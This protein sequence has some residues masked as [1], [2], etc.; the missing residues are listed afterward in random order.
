MR[1]KRI[2]AVLL[3][4]VLLVSLFQAP[5]SVQAAAGDKLIALTFDDGP[6]RTNT[7]QLLDGLKQRGVNVTFFMVGSNVSSNLSLV[8][9]AYDEGHEVAGHTYD[10]PNLNTLGTAEIKSQLSRTTQAL[11]QACGSG[12][13]YLLRPPY[14]NANATVLSA[15]GTPAILWSV[16]TNDWK[17]R[18][19]NHVRDHIVSY[20]SDGAIILCHDLYGTTVSGALAAVDVLLSKGYE[21][22]TVSELYRRRGVTLQDGVK[23]YSLKNNGKDSGPIQQ[24]NIYVTPVDGGVYITMHSPSGAP[25]YYSLGGERITSQSARYTGGFYSTSPVTIQAV[26]AY[27]LNG[28]RS[29]TSKVVLNHPTCTR[30]EIQTSNG[31]LQLTCSSKGADIYYTL[32]GEKPTTASTK[33]QG[34]IGIRPGTTIRAV[35]GGANYIVSPETKLHYSAKGNLF[36]DVYPEHWYYE[37]IDTITAMGLMQGLGNHIFAPNEATTRAMLVTMLYRY[38]GET[39]EEG[40]QR[41]NTFTDV[42]DGK[43]YSEAVEWAYRNDVVDGYTDHTFRQNQPVTREEMAKIYYGFLKHR[44]ITMDTSV[45]HR[46]NFK[47]GSRIHSWAV[48]SVNAIVSSGLMVGHGDGNFYPGNPASRAETGTVLVRIHELEK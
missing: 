5:A 41:T 35:A 29:A 17:Y 23:Y 20:A 13:K 2:T 7:K 39:L 9:R 36:A 28:D 3:L 22:V 24:P 18:D 31:M 26:A 15:I 12:T 43:W 14:G 19:A 45:D 38:S 1:K 33:Y 47:D 4:L 11:D 46:A 27:D 8:K 48:E 30:P 16:D 34:P 32:N 37:S 44:G 42:A 25:I 40:W 21:F 6:H 10:H